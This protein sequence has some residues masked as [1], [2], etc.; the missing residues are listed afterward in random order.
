MAVH[1]ELGAG[2]LEA[3]YE[4][5]LALEMIEQLIDFK[6]QAPFV[7]NYGGQAVGQ[8]FADFFIEDQLIIEM[9]A[10]PTL[11]S[12]C[13]SQLLHYLKCSKMPL[14]L[15]LNFGSK[16]LQVKRMVSEY[17]LPKVPSNSV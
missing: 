11:T 16:S 2:F 7:V 3:V 5:A 12:K 1:K 13:E 10:L 4:R 9:K 15:L 17:A 6:R 14:G 8:Y